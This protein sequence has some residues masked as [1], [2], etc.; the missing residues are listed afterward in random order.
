M[1][2]RD[3]S[4]LLVRRTQ[5]P[6]KGLWSVPGGLV[7]LGETVEDAARR[8]AKE[9]TGIEVRIEKLLDVIDSVVYDDQRKIRFHYVLII[10]LAHPLTTAAEPHA[11]VSEVRW[12]HFSDLSSYPM[13]KSAKKLL[14]KI[15]AIGEQSEKAG[16]SFP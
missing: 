4:V 12:V 15:G 11:D 16:S 13:T 10:F 9:E 6:G 2:V 7:E 14:L 1:I 3:S 8:E 5:E